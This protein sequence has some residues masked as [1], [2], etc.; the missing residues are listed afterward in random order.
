MQEQ[1]SLTP[2]ILECN[3]DLPNSLVEYANATQ[4]ASEEQ[5]AEKATEERITKM[6]T[7]ES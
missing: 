6:F 2:G 7:S 4:E 1:V 3:E 5:T